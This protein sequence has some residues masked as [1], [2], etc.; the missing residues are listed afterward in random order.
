MTLDLGQLAHL[1]LADYCK[2]ACEH[3]FSKITQHVN[4]YLLK[5]YLQ[6]LIRGTKLNSLEAEKWLK[7]VNYFP[8]V[9]QKSCLQDQSI[10]RTMEYD[11]LMTCKFPRTNT[12]TMPDVIAELYEEIHAYIPGMN[13]LKYVTYCINH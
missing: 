4:L 1:F 5:T 13:F 11:C 7:I 3:S 8:L 2:I 12:C 6:I 9:G 10:Y